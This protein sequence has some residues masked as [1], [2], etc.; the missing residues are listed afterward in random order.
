M[1]QPMYT[2]ARR[3]TV[4]RG[5]YTNEALSEANSPNLPTIKQPGVGY[6]IAKRLVDIIGALCGII[7]LSPVFLITALMVATD[8]RGT[9]FH[10]RRVL[11][12]Q[13]YEGGDLLQFDAFKFRTMVVNADEVLKRDP[14]LLAEYQKDFKLAHDPRITRIGHILR[15]TSIDELP[16]LFNVLRGQMSLVGPRMITAP[17]LAMYEENASKLLSV[18]PGITGL[19]QVSGRTNLSYKERVRLDMWYIDNRSVIMDLQIL[20]RTVECVLRRRGAV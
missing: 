19:W 3:D 1:E 8:S 17:E 16:Q 20:I 12:Q 6:R 11:H 15:K 14:K 5:N 10:R 9:I 13:E 2:T 4:L 18:K 7:L